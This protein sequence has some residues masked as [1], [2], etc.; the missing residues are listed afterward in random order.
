M[1]EEILGNGQEPTEQIKQKMYSLAKENR[2]D[3]LYFWTFTLTNNKASA[4]PLKED[5]PFCI[6]LNQLCLT[7]LPRQENV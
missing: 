6:F 3:A 4:L 1:S 7:N 2:E 5:E